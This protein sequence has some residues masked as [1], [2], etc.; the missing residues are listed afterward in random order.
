M[1]E[2]LGEILNSKENAQASFSIRELISQKRP[3]PPKEM[4]TESLTT[5]FEKRFSSLNCE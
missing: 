3:P 2:E 5:H 1:L 4:D